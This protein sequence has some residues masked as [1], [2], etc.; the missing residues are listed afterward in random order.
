MPRKYTELERQEAQDRAL[1][2]GRAAV[3]LVDYRA[4]PRKQRHRCIKCH[5][6]YRL[7]GFGAG[8]GEN[9]TSSTGFQT[10]CK[11]CKAT[12]S[13]KAMKETPES[14]IRHHFNTRMQLQLGEYCPTNFTRDMD[15]YVGYKTRDL[16]RYLSKELKDREGPQQNLRRA[17]KLGYHIDHIRP[18]KLYDVIDYANSEVRWDTFRECWAMENLMCI[19]GEENL[20]KGSRYVEQEEEAENGP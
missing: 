13:T 3:P 17:F 12:R 7:R 19:P 20:K 2:K 16:V 10:I 15:D 1:E 11:T 8:F 9:A 14:R 4:V 5:H 6:W 18:L